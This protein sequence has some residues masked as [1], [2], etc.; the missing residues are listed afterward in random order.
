[1]YECNPDATTNAQRSARR[2]RLDSIFQRDEGVRFRPT[3]RSPS[4][5]LTAP[6]RKEAVDRRASPWD[7][8]V[9]KRVTKSSIGDKSKTFS[10]NEPRR[11]ELLWDSIYESLKYAFTQATDDNSTFFV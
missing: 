1:M 4:M 6:K 9:V 11:L 2:I 3:P 5:V 8:G 10:G 7:M